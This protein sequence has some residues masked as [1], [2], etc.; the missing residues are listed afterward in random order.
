MKITE[1][2]Y[3]VSIT[4]MHS[5]EQTSRVSAYIYAPSAIEALRR[6]A[7]RFGVDP[8]TLV[9]ASV[10]TGNSSRTYEESTT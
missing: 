4:L 1:Q 5:D 10:E 8:E 2:G 6:L 3:D 7:A 9:Y